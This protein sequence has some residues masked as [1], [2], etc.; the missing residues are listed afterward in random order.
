MKFIFILL[1]WLAVIFSIPL[2]IRSV[3]E[4]VKEDRDTFE[5]KKKTDNKKGT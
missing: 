1:F 5:K 2:V 4:A 3:V